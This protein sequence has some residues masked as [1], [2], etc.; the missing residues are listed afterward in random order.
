[1]L[2]VPVEDASAL[3]AVVRRLEA[4]Q[5]DVTELALQLPGLNEVFFSLTGRPAESSPEQEL[6]N[7]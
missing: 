5:I 1:V 6:V 4:A 3:G 7:S 2:K